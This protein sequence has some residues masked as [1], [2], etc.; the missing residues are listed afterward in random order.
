MPSQ[1]FDKVADKITSESKRFTALSFDLVD[2]IHALLEKHDMTQRDL[3]DKMGKRESEI[4]KWLAP[5]HNFTLK[6]LVKLEIAL[7]EP[8]IF[9]PG[10]ANNAPVSGLEIPYSRQDEPSPKRQE[11]SGKAR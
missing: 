4:S 6:T 10:E 3:A 7:G 8:L 1:Y 9:I 5:G 2:Y 11:V